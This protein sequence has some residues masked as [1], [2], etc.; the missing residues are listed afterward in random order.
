MEYRRAI[1][2]DDCICNEFTSSVTKSFA[3]L[4]AEGEN[5]SNSFPTAKYGVHFAFWKKRTPVAGDQETKLRHDH[6]AAYG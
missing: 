6:L 3:A 1:G 4:I 2:D 5:R